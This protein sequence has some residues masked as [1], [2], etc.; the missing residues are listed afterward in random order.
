MSADDAE[1]D[2]NWDTF[3]KEIAPSA[4]VKTEFMQAEIN[5]LIGK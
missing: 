3:V 1:L 5:K 2:A 4:K